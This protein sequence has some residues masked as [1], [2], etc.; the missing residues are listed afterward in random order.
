MDDQ[1]GGRDR[2]VLISD[3]SKPDPCDRR[4]GP[5]DLRPVTIMENAREFGWL[6]ASPASTAASV[7]G[8]KPQHLLTECRRIFSVAGNSASSERDQPSAAELASRSSVPNKP[9]T[10]LDGIQMCERRSDDN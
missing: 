10:R 2:P 8:T 3:P 5:P 4:E 1:A 9:M 7:A 6:P